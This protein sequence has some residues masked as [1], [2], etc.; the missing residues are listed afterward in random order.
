MPHR[1]QSGNDHPQPATGNVELSTAS[2][3]L[4]Q[5]VGLGVFSTGTILLGAG[6]E[7]VIDFLYGLGG[8]S[9]VV[10]RIVLPNRVVGQLA[11]ALESNQAGKGQDDGKKDDASDS[12][13]K[14][15]ILSTSSQSPTAKSGFVDGSSGNSPN[16]EQKNDKNS[17]AEAPEEL[18]SDNDEPESTGNREEATTGSAA[19]SVEKS[20]GRKESR[21]LSQPNIEDIY[22]GLRLPESL[23]AGSFANRVIV[24]STGPECILDFVAQ[25]YPKPCVSARVIMTA[26]R[27]PALLNSL[28][29]HMTTNRIR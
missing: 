15:Q 27:V 18:S 23:M 17:A 12:S 22:S 8:Q 3:R 6:Q 14:K 1:D 10:A 7:T 20:K 9:H 19:E 11:K 16:E 2:A 25:L 21:S 24:R 4:P 5:E 13:P 26:E 29:Q 28:K